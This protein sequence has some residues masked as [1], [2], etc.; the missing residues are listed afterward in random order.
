MIRH[1]RVVWAFWIACGLAAV[2]GIAP[3]LLGGFSSRIGAV[4][5]PFAVAAAALAGCA[6]LHQQGRP[7]ATALYFLAGLAIV[8]GILSLIAVPLRLAVIGTCPPL[9]AACPAGLERPLTAGESTGLAFAIGMGIVAILTGF[10]GLVTLY[11]RSATRVE[12]V[13][14]PV[15]RIA[16]VGTRPAGAA[17]DAVAPAAVAPADAAP[18]EAAPPA[19]AHEPAELPAPEPQLELPAHSEPVPAAPA[20]RKPRRRRVKLA[21]PPETPAA[22]PETQAAPPETP[23]DTGA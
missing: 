5:I 18:I 9:P 17:P 20:A 19:P 3:L 2:A 7:V 11:R 8:Y 4:A 16:P 13:T 22:P 15:R 23:A 10:F 14:P 1:P 12:P 6:L 21:G